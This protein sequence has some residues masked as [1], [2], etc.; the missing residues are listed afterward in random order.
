MTASGFHTIVTTPHVNHTD[1]TITLMT[2]YPETRAP[3]REASVFCNSAVHSDEWISWSGNNLMGQEHN[4]FTLRKFRWNPCIDRMWVFSEKISKFEYQ[5][6]FQRRKMKGCSGTTRQ[7]NVFSATPPKFH[8]L[9]PHVFYTTQ[10]C[11][12]LSEIPKGV[13]KSHESMLR[14]I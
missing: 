8:E 6:L 9:V 11:S 10:T 2:V 14:L 5:I 7:P 4:F 12:V 3:D 13:R 1:R